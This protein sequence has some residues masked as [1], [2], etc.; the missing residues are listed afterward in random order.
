[1]GAVEMAL[2]AFLGF[3]AAIAALSLVRAANRPHA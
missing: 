1:M 3:N 2:I